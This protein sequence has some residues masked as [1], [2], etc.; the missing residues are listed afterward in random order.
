VKNIGGDIVK[1]AKA[2]GVSESILSRGNS[3]NQ[4]AEN[5][6][7]ST[8]QEELEATPERSE[9]FHAVAPRSGSCYSRQP[10]WLDSRCSGRSGVVAKNYDEKLGQVLRQPELLRFIRSKIA[11][12]SPDLQNDPLVKSV[13]DQLGANRADCGDA[14]RAGAF[15]GRSDE[16]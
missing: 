5:D 14:L 15:G 11:Q 16:A 8:L 1:M 7:W 12:V 13:N 3:I 2:L 10:R 6:E 9:G 4:F